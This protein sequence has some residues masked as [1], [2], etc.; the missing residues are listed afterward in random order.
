[1][2]AKKTKNVVA[3]ELREIGEKY[4]ELKLNEIGL[5]AVARE[6]LATLACTDDMEAR[7]VFEKLADLIEEA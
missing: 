3:A 4:G 5:R 2:K 7:E 1:M 6:I